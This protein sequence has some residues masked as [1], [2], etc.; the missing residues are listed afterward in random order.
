MFLLE[1][2]KVLLPLTDCCNLRCKYCYQPKNEYI[3]MSKEI[4]KKTLDMLFKDIEEI[5]IRTLNIFGGEPTLN[6]EILEYIIDYYISYR[7]RFKYLLKFQIN[8]NLQLMDSDIIRIFKKYHEKAE[9]D[10]VISIDGVKEINDKYR[11]GVNKTNTY[12]NVIKNVNTLRK[13]FK[14]IHLSSCS[15][16][17]EEHT[18]DYELLKKSVIFLYNTFDTC[19]I[20]PLLPGTFKGSL[21]IENIIKLFKELNGESDNKLKVMFR[22]FVPEGG[23][24]DIKLGNIEMCRAGD[25]LMMINTDGYI[26]PCDLYLAA[27]NP[28]NFALCNIKDIEEFP[29]KIDKN[30]KWIKYQ[31]FNEKYYLGYTDLQNEKGEKCNKC[32][33]SDVCSPCIAYNEL[34][35]DVYTMKQD[36]CDKNKT[37]FETAIKI[38]GES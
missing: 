11:V 36:M 26:Y 7:S 32:E 14:N 33:F 20:T 30:N 24:D 34:H 25:S 21:N 27:E 37:K 22:N 35:N 4:A 29:I 10:F 2:T 17:T 15:V 28:K 18:N 38:L 12:D 3:F 8:T 6:K 31:R 5:G 13:E 19:T 9:T 1:P 23:V 16:L